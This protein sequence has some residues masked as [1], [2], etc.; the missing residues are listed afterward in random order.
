MDLNLHLTSLSEEYTA[1]RYHYR[2]SI[3]KAHRRIFDECLDHLD[4]A[5][6]CDRLLVIAPED[7]LALIEQV[8]ARPVII[9]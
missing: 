3:A 8:K 1:I 6:S 4:D 9:Y 2:S 7:P 5:T